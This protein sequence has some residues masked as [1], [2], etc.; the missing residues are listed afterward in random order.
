MADLADPTTENPKSDADN[1]Y[2]AYKDGNPEPLYRA[3]VA[4]A[5]I[6]I[7]KN[8]GA[9]DPTLCHQIAER[10][11]LAVGKFRGG[12][13]ISTWFYK[14]AENE[15]KRE[16]RRQ[17]T[18]R[19]RYPDLESI[20]PGS[21]DS[22]KLGRDAVRVFKAQ[23]VA[24]ETQSSMGKAFSALPPEQREVA[25]LKQKGFSFREIAKKTD[26]STATAASRWRLAKEKLQKNLTD[27]D[28]K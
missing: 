13:K 11:L 26:V 23:M 4:Q 18:T 7:W 28:K 3:F 21:K 20:K 22:K 10:G 17:I 8:L 9:M 12:S 2:Q 6:A 5:R 24:S 27:D 16:L 19:N 15:C 25:L 1:A 14:I